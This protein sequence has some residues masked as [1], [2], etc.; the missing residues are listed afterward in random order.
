M[1]YKTI[2]FCDEK[3]W[4]FGTPSNKQN[5]KIWIEKNQNTNMK[6]IGV[7]KHGVAINSFAAINWLGQS[8]IKFYVDDI[9][10]ENNAKCV[11]LRFLLN[12][13]Y[14]LHSNILLSLF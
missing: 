3:P 14:L 9:N 11:Y 4:V 10:Y 13:F 1:W 7:D 5:N 2:T 8:D 6:N 12:F